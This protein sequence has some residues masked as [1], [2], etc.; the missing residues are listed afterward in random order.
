LKGPA[1]SEGPRHERRCT[2]DSARAPV[3]DD[4]PVQWIAFNRPEVKNAQNVRML[5]D[6]EG[7]LGGAASD[8]SIRAPVLAGA[9][10][11]F[12]SG[13]D[14]A[15]IVRILSTP[16][17]PARLRVGIGRSS[18]YSLSRSNPPCSCHPDNLPCAGVLPRLVNFVV[19]NAELDAK[20]CD[21]VDLLLKVPREAL[22]LSKATFQF[23]AEA[24]GERSLARF[25]YMTRQLSHHT[26]ASRNIV[27]GRVNRLRD[28]GSPLGG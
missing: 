21:V 27:A 7:K 19:P 10:D 5:C 25:H 16:T 1:D 12:T 15:E 17:M 13:H 8:R 4:G 23:M 28:G 6:L 3:H 14:L 22:A 9:G 18:T 11:S 2:H 24:M 20:V 26:D